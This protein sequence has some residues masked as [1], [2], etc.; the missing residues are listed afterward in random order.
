MTECNKCGTSIR[1]RSYTVGAP[2]DI[3]LCHNCSDDFYNKQFFIELCE[4]CGCNYFSEFSEPPFVCDACVKIALSAPSR[5]FPVPDEASR[6][7]FENWCIDRAIKEF[8]KEHQ[9]MGINERR[10][11]VMEQ[12]AVERGNPRH[13]TLAAKFCKE[14]REKNL[15]FW[16]YANQFFARWM[17]EEAFKQLREIQMDQALMVL[18]TLLMDKKLEQAGEPRTHYLS[19]I[20]SI[21]MTVCP[22][23][24][25]EMA[26]IPF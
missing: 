26:G 19:Y 17:V 20:D 1:H 11:V 22:Y 12:F 25:D 7:P 2:P 3:Q 18:Q 6:P 15:L 23:A 16:E 13:I 14:A 5:Y 10:R 8:I 24:D 9:R 21:N 4:D